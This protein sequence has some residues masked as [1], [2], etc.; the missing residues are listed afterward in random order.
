[1]VKFSAE[2]VNNLREIPFATVMANAE[3]FI[4]D[5]VYNHVQSQSLAF[6]LNRETGKIIR[7]CSRGSSSFA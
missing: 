2:L 6:H 4:A 7:I 1:V 5:K 3:V